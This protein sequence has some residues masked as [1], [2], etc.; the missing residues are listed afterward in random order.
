M[1]KSVLVINDGAAR[2]RIV[3]TVHRGGGIRHIMSFVFPLQAA[4]LCITTI[5]GI[6]LY[7]GD[8]GPAVHARLNN[9]V[10]VA[11]DSGGNIYIADT[12]NHRVRKVNLSGVITTVTGTGVQGFSGD[13]GQAASAMLNYPNGVAVDGAGNL[14][15]ADGNNA[16]IRK[17]NAAGVI[18]TVAGNGSW[19]SSGD[20]GPA[21]SARTN[22]QILTC[23]RLLSLGYTGI[24]S[25]RD[26][27]R[28]W[29]EASLPAEKE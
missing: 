26:G 10:S 23:A 8:D 2:P 16:R 1:I 21:T 5:A 4:E 25:F 20:G 22:P 17:V 29:I 18:T 24:L 28:K 15:I 3:S 19:G 27:W 7:S 13:G 9:P 12:S 11:R 14:F 6:G